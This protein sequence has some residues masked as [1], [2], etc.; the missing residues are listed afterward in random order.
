MAAKPWRMRR[1]ERVEER[2][3]ELME[4]LGTALEGRF[5]RSDL[6]NFRIRKMILGNF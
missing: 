3:G 5:V 4:I 6:E 1:R 2:I